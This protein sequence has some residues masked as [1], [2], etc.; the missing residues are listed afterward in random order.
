MHRF[1]TA[2]DVDRPMQ[3]RNWLKLFLRGPVI[4]FTELM[5]GY[6][7]SLKYGL[8]NRNLYGTFF[9]W[10]NLELNHNCFEI[11]P[12]SFVKLNHIARTA[13]IIPIRPRRLLPYPGVPAWAAS[14]VKTLTCKAITMAFAHCNLQSSAENFEWSICLQIHF[15]QNLSFFFFFSFSLSGIKIFINFK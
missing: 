10:T 9:Y 15:T 7:S 4:A 2:R 1:V 6:K 5:V 13:K 12:E 11:K 8:L 3:T 14:L